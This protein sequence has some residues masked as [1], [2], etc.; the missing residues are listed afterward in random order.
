MKEWGFIG[1][2][3]FVGIAKSATIKK[4][5]QRCGLVK[6]GRFVVAYDFTKGLLINFGAISLQ[7][8]LVFKLIYNEPN[9]S[10][11]SKIHKS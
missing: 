2:E 7:Y 9:H 3:I 1:Q 5:K 10:V 4:F 6:V 11:N 8:K